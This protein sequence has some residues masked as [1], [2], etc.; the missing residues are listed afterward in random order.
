M[1]YKS[2][3]AACQQNSEKIIPSCIDGEVTPEFV[4][5]QY[6][7][8][9]LERRTNFDRFQSLRAVDHA[10]A[11]P[12]IQRGHPVR[13]FYTGIQPSW[14]YEAELGALSPSDLAL[15]RRMC[16]LAAGHTRTQAGYQYQVTGLHIRASRYRRCC[17]CAAAM[18]AE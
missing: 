15:S 6:L 14:F 3:S 12:E 13:L 9:L 18:R 2:L 11:E 16:R 17:D 8:T 10:A 4:C 5:R 1:E 7:R